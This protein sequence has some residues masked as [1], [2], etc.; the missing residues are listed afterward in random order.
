MA[1]E[2]EFGFGSLAAALAVEDLRK[3]EVFFQSLSDALAAAATVAA[4]AAAFPLDPFEP[5]EILAAA[6]AGGGAIL[7]NRASRFFGDT[8]DQKERSLAPKTAD[9]VADDESRKQIETA[10]QRLDDAS[11]TFEALVQAFGGSVERIDEAS[12]EM[13]EA[14]G[15]VFGEHQ[16]S[17]G[18]NGP[19]GRVQ[20]ASYTP[21]G[22][23]LADSGLRFAGFGAS[24]ESS[25][26][27]GGILPEAGRGFEELR[28]QAKGALG[29]IDAAAEQT[30]RDIEGFL[31]HS[32]E[33]GKF[34]W[35][36]FAGVALDAIGKI[37]Q[38]QSGIGGGGGGIFDILLGLGSSFLG[39]FGGGGGPTPLMLSGPF[40]HG[41]RPPPGMAALVGEQG[42][43]LFVPDV[44]GTIVPNDALGGPGGERVVVN[45][46]YTID[47]RGASP[48]MEQ[49][50][51]QAL[52]V[53]E[54][55]AVN[56]AKMDIIRDAQRGGIF[57]RLP[58]R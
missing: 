20:R 50:I 14:I 57:S 16:G 18:G 48:G 41:G 32:L 40:A 52:K 36:D 24:G 45:N 38:A 55:N 37:F 39:G 19:Q 53:T 46:N 17:P 58:R 30:F 6:G 44:P 31:K 3:L 51:M 21:S 54:Q 27:G 25:R 4:A 26:P 1:S 10:I 7:T 8:A 22:G 9:D 29:E 2:N 15:K 56:R 34:E 28:D 23:S 33:A 13:K 12:K 11:L 42:P 5:A 47:A 35:R 43:E 49:R